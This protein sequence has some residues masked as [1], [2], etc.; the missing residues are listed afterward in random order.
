MPTMILGNQ[1][2]VL[3]T[4]LTN[5]KNAVK[6]ARNSNI[7]DFSITNINDIIK[8]CIIRAWGDISRVLSGI[9]NYAKNKATA[10]DL[11]EKELISYFNSSP[12][13]QTGFDSWHNSLCKEVIKCF[14]GYTRKN[15]NVDFTYAC[16]QKLINMTFKY[17]YCF[18]IIQNDYIK[19]IEYFKYCHMAID[20]KILKWLKQ[21]K[22]KA[23]LFNEQDYIGLQALALNAQISPNQS[24]VSLCLLEKEMIVWNK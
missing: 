11:I 24:N 9:N 3:Q 6:Q 2:T 23:T 16:A 15:S 10:F 19:Y 14:I 5:F 21:S 17:I 13:P 4:E 7:R 12:L 18:D 22:L 20:S 8:T 1:C